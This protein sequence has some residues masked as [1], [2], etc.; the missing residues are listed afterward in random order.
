MI[1]PIP[2][3]LLA[4]ILFFGIISVLIIR[5]R[6][7]VDF[8]YGLIIKRWKKGNKVMDKW[9]FSHKKILNKLGTIGVYIGVGASIIA[10]ISIIY[11]V[12]INQ[13]AAALILPTVNNY[14]YPTDAIV[15]VPF[16]F[17]IISIFVVLVVH[18]PMHAIY[19]RLAGIPVKSWG[20]MLL[21]FIPIGA[22]VDPDMRKVNKLKFMQKMKIY[23]GGS[24]GNFVTAGIVL[25]ITF[26][27]G[28]LI[29]I[30]GFQIPILSELLQWLFIF[31]IGIGIFNMLP[32]KP[33]D[34]GLMFETIFEKIFK[35]KK[36]ASTAIK[37]SSIIVLGIIIMAIFGKEIFGII[38]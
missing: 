15:G 11:L 10:L 20:V 14:E 6:K 37:I 24:F 21:L 23:A 31:N 16:W 5:D 3:D 12:S 26:V 34:G 1:T 28:F 18:E 13:Q 30:F 7:N 19:S 2:L 33:L 9:I 36:K 38:L 25:L 29:K 27:Y 32:M 22:F 35:S 17:W 8:H 4:M